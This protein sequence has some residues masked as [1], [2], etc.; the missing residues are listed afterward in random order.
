MLFAR[1]QGS[2]P[3]RQYLGHSGDS[4]LFHVLEI[5]GCRRMRVEGKSGTGLEFSISVNL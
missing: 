5:L 2:R 1:G 4:C 3:Q